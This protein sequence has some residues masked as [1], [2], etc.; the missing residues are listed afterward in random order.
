MVCNSGAN[1]VCMWPC[2]VQ[3]QLAAARQ[4]IAEGYVTGHCTMQSGGEQKNTAE[5][6]VHVCM[7]AQ[8][9]DLQQWWHL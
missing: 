3:D 8:A 5:D 2:V 7:M 9:A 4:Q 1:V 6:N